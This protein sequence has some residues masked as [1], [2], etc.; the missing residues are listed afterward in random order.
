MY[1]YER[2]TVHPSH[3]LDQLDLLALGL[4]PLGGQ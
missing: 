2:C 3:S 1:L 4:R